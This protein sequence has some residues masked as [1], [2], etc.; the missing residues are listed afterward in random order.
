M[1]A[2]LLG[3]LLYFAPIKPPQKPVQ[4]QKQYTEDSKLEE[5]LAYVRQGTDPMKGI[6]MLREMVEKDSSNVLA[7]FYLGEFSLQSGQLDKAIDRFNKV[8]LLDSNYKEA[9][10]M[11]AKAWT[12]KGDSAMAMKHANLY[13]K[14]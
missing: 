3:V 10:K 2:L 12:E 1:G 8:L 6:M 11:L 7:H 5:A 14:K 4:E 13:S 9:Y